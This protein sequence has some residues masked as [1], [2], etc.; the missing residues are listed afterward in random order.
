MARTTDS[1]KLFTL[2]EPAGYAEASVTTYEAA[3][4][5]AGWDRAR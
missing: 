5:R 1:G 2:Y 3:A 4:E